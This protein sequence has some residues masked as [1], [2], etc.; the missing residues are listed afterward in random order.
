MGDHLPEE[1]AGFA[2]LLRCG[3]HFLRAPS[4]LMSAAMNIN[5]ALRRS[6]PADLFLISRRRINS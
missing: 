4:T 1:I 3:E 5:S 6:S 2:F